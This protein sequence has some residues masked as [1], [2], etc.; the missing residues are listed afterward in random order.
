MANSKWAIVSEFQFLHTAY[1]SVLPRSQCVLNNAPTRRLNGDFMLSVFTG[2]PRDVH[3]SAII[4]N[5]QLKTVEGFE[6]ILQTSIKDV[7]T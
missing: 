1:P 6:M 5:K 7:E 3:P 2:R 4:I